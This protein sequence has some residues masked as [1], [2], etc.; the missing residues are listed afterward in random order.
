MCGTCGCHDEHSTVHLHT[1]D[2]EIAAIEPHTH[3][4]RSIQ[5]EQSILAKNDKIAHQNQHYFA[6]RHIYVLNVV[7]SPGSGKTTLMTKTIDRLKDRVRVGVIVGD[8]ATD[9][10]AQRLR[11]TGVPVVQITTGTLCHLEAQMI[12]QA[13]EQLPLDN[14]DL[15][16]IENVGNL[17]CPA[18]YDLGENLRIV[19]LSVTEGEDK[20]LK[21]PTMFKSADIAIVNKMD[22]AAA[23]EFDRPTA[24]QNLHKLAPQAE[25]F[26]VSAKTGLGMEEWCDRLLQSCRSMANLSEE[27]NR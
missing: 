11:S 21:Y 26:E 20:P 8:L 14:I 7:S 17:V 19:L 25:I 18:A 15:L 5:V 24:L 16:I 13:A 4:H 2:R 9:N 10:D 3:P 6:D 27:C 1:P 12:R 22:L 23:V